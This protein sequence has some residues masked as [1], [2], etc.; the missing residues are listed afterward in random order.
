MI[1]ESRYLAEDAAELIEI[2]Y[3]PLGAVSDPER[4]VAAAAPLLHEQAGTNV[5][6]AREFK[7][8]DVAAASPTRTSECGIASR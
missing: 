2:E 1:A 6:I 3:E 5:L 4:N 8:G 7:K